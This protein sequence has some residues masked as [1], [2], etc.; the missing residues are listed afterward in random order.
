MMIA[1]PLAAATSWIQVVI[2]LADLL[3]KRQTLSAW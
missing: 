1:W 2:I 3:K